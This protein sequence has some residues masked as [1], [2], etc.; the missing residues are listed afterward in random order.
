M[1]EAL[2]P[3]QTTLVLCRAYMTLA[4]KGLKHF[5]LLIQD[6]FVVFGFYILAVYLY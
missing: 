6:F 4:L 3:L 1:Y 2:Y 5:S